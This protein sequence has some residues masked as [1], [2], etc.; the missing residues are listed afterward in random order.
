[1]SKLVLGLYVE[2]STDRRFL[3]PIIERIATEILAKNNRGDVWD[4]TIILPIE[5]TVRKRESQAQKILA[6]AIE[7]CGCYLLII[8]ADAD[9][10]TAAEARKNRFNPGLELVRQAGGNV[11]Q[12][13]LPIVPIQEIEAWLLA[14]KEALLKVLETNKNVAELGIPPIRKI[15]S[16][17]QPKERLEGIIR[18]ANQ[19]RRY[20]IDRDDL[21]EPLGETVRL[22]KLA[23]LSAYQQF[24]SD[25]TDVLINLGIILRAPR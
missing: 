21:Y 18:I 3:Q 4:D 20:H 6:A 13:I 1:M 10:P 15:E 11:C 23:G 25:L 7:A 12:D 22:E 16:T 17:A 8:H 5:P 14:D 2:G 24:I 9:G 19:F